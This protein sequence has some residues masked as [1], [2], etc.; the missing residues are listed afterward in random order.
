LTSSVVV[1]SWKSYTNIEW[2]SLSF[3]VFIGKAAYVIAFSPALLFQK[4]VQYQ[5]SFRSTYPSGVE[6]LALCARAEIASTA[7]VELLHRCSG[8]DS[9]H[10]YLPQPQPHLRRHLPPQSC[11]RSHLFHSAQQR[12][13]LASSTARQRPSADPR[14]GSS[15]EG[16]GER[17]GRSCRG[18]GRSYIF[19]LPPAPTAPESAFCGRSCAEEF[20]PAHLVALCQKQLP[21]RQDEHYQMHPE[22]WCSNS[23]RCKILRQLDPHERALCIKMK[24]HCL[25]LA[26]LM[27]TMMRQRSKITYLAEGHANT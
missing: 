8:S 9:P 18:S 17:G 7:S 12:P 2:L 25:G 24:L 19:Q 14:A 11:W 26:S 13:P 16:K 6:I 20:F 4:G 22:S 3:I 1:S 21:E 10:H 15:L 5:I 23:T 27:R